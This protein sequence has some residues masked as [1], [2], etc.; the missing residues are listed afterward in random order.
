MGVTM[1]TFEVPGGGLRSGGVGE[2][3][4]KRY[5]IKTKRPRPLRRYGRRFRKERRRWSVE[6][7]A[8]VYACGCEVLRGYGNCIIVVHAVGY[9]GDSVCGLLAQER[10]MASRRGCRMRSSRSVVVVS[11]VR[12]VWLVFKAP[13][14]QPAISECDCLPNAPSQVSLS[15]PADANTG[16]WFPSFFPSSA[17]ELRAT[18]SRN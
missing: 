1:T 4:R 14:P 15:V 3:G 2:D 13:S 17:D 5:M 11:R 16:S 6:A 12:F 8:D 9:G 10:N 18:T 7:R